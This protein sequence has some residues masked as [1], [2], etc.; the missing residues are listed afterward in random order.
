MHRG[1][2]QYFKRKL[3]RSQISEDGRYLLASLL[4][5][6]YDRQIF[7]LFEGARAHEFKNSSER[8]LDL[9]VDAFKRR[10][11]MIADNGPC[12]EQLQE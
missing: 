3:Q 7:E 4:N 10:R 9:W 12:P 1:Y 5:R 2:R 8:T 6:V 11:S